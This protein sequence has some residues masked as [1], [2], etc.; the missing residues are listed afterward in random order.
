MRPNTAV[1]RP[2]TTQYT[3]RHFIGQGVRPSSHARSIPSQARGF[4]T[5]KDHLYFAKSTAEGSGRRNGVVKSFGDTPLEFKTDMPKVAGGKGEG[6]NPE[7]LFGMGYATCFL[8]SLQLMAARAGK[9]ELGEKAKVHSKVYLGHPKDP[10]LEG[11]GL[12][13]ELSVEGIE[14]DDIIAAAHNFCAYSRALTQGCEVT[15]MK[16]RQV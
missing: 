9:K 16:A 12:R 3:S 11:F 14:D 10:N 15:V 7:Q 4:L 6:V 5:L 8:G 1:L 2:L 13:V